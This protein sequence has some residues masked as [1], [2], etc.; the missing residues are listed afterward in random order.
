MQFAQTGDVIET[1]SKF[2]DSS[3]VSQVKQVSI[4]ILIGIYS[5]ISLFSAVVIRRNNDQDFFM[6]YWAIL[7]ITAY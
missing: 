2:L 6:E 7:A 4:K 5:K 3:V 1:I